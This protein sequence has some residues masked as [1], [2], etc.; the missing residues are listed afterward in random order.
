MTV[1]INYLIDGVQRA[2]I[3]ENASGVIKNDN[4]F[5]VVKGANNRRF[6]DA[7]ITSFCMINGVHDNDD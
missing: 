6:D 5:L 1:I 3:I 7:A 4:G 2:E